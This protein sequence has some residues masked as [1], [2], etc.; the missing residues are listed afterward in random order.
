MVEALCY[1][2]G[3]F[4][5]R[6]SS[7]LLFCSFFVFLSLYNLFGKISKINKACVPFINKWYTKGVSF[8]PRMD[9]ILKGKGLDHGT[10]LPQPPP[11]PP[12]SKR[13][14]KLVKLYLSRIQYI[15]KETKPYF[16]LWPTADKCLVNFRKVP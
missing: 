7:P 16:N 10:E 9:H 2:P 1:K 3:G 6:L 14:L 13:C 15:Y 4:Y 11:H 12:D 8:L 5:L